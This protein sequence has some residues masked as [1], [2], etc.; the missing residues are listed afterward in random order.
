MTDLMWGWDRAAG[1]QIRTGTAADDNIAGEK[2]GEKRKNAFFSS[3]LQ[4]AAPLPKCPRQQN[5]SVFQPQWQTLFH[6]VT[7]GLLTCQD[8]PCLLTAQ[9]FFGGS[10]LGSPTPP[11]K[12]WE[13]AGREKNKTEGERKLALVCWSSSSLPNPPLLPPPLLL[14][15]SA[16]A[17]L[18]QLSA[19]FHSDATQT[20]L[21]V[22]FVISPSEGKTSSLTPTPTPP[23]SSSRIGTELCSA[24][25]PGPAV[26]WA[27]VLTHRCSSS[28]SLVSAKAFNSSRRRRWRFTQS[29]MWWFWVAAACDAQTV[30]SSLKL[31]AEFHQSLIQTH[32][33]KRETT[34]QQ[35][36]TGFAG[37]TITLSNTNRHLIFPLL[38]PAAAIQC[39]LTSDLWPGPSQNDYL[40][41][42][43]N[44]SALCLFVCFLL[45][46]SM[47]DW[48]M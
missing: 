40:Y 3:I 38:F 32:R 20:R 47:S 7:S 22:V 2:R 45:V 24:L 4:A 19:R 34:S 15:L 18:Q 17:P 43:V 36:Q 14:L 39:H 9:F 48:L 42:C 27:P 16:L 23:S 1:L 30:A 12:I 13:G 33:P 29:V 46:L 37:Q 28:S 26:H 35:H 44:E 41:N 5:G 10:R 21:I 31:A 8:S 6:H 11:L 25:T